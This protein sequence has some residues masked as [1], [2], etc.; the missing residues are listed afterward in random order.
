MSKVV[1]AVCT[2]GIAKFW[3]LLDAHVF[4]RCTFGIFVILGG[5]HEFFMNPAMKAAP[6]QSPTLDSLPIA[7][8]CKLRERF[9]LAARQHG[10]RRTFDGVK[11]LVIAGFPKVMELCL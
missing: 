9:C 3:I 6:S 4:R 7:L 11:L 8:E 2:F 1:P 10:R 5:L